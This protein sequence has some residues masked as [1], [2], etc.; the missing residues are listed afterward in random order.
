MVE[1]VA[2]IVL[3]GSRREPSNQAVGFSESLRETLL[4]RIL[5]LEGPKEANEHLC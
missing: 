3:C 4:D 2:G 5:N 1:S